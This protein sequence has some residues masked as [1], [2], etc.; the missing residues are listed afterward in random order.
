ML[1]AI[2]DPH[3]N[4]N[5]I[6]IAGTNGKGSTC[7]IINR[8]LIESG[9]TVGLY[10]SPHL[11]NFNERIKV[12]DQEISDHDIAQFMKRNETH[13]RKINTT[14]FDTTTEMAFDY[15]HKLSV[16]IAIIE[17]GL[18]GRLDSTNVVN[19]SLTVMTPISLD[20][21]SYTHLTLPTKRIV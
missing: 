19:P 21:V 3:S 1:K 13:I 20:P 2:G 8:I 16:D 17:T 14:F 6:H 18:G 11:I 12:N 15:F 5:C 10:T 7:A 4:L 9:L